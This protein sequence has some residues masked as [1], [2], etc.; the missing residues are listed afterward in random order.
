MINL[1]MAKVVTKTFTIEDKRPLFQVLFLKDDKNDSVE[2]EETN[3][4]DFQKVKDHLRNG[5]AVFITRRHSPRSSNS[6]I[7]KQS[8][9]NSSRIAHTRGKDGRRAS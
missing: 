5:E 6:L 9:L 3:E 1:K 2:V 4:V 7:S 8:A